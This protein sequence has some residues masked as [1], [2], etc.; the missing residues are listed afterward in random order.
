MNDMVNS[1][2]HYT[3]H[4]SGVECADVIENL[5]H[6]ISNPVKY[7]WRTD[8]KNGREDLEESLWYL[9]RASRM[10]WLQ[11]YFMPDKNSTAWAVGEALV[12]EEQGKPL[13]YLL[14]AVQCALTGETGHA[15]NYAGQAQRKIEQ[16]LK[17]EAPENNRVPLLYEEVM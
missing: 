5:P 12:A 4:P 15:V 8:H 14:H 9:K 7:N 10:N 17:A 6:N 11:I 3:S 2:K 13:W 16:Q 1:P